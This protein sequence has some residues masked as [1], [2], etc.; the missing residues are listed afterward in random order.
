MEC[1]SETMIGLESGRGGAIVL[2]VRRVGRRPVSSETDS[3]RLMLAGS[4][5]LRGILTGWVSK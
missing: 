3:L 5:F 2:S 4:G 1:S